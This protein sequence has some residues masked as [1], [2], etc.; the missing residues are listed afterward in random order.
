MKS[1]SDGMSSSEEAKPQQ[2]GRWPMNRWL[3]LIVVVLAAHVALIFTFG[4]RKPVT[5]RVAS[6]V[7]ELE[8]DSRS[9]EWLMLQDPTLFA[10]PSREGFAGAA[11]LE[12]PHLEIHV[13]DW[14]ESPRFLSLLTNKLGATFSQFMQTNR[15]A[16]F[17]FELKP[18]PQFSVPSVPLEP[19]FARTSTLR[20]EG[21]LAQ[22][23][24][25]TA[26]KLPSWPYADIIAPSRVQVLVNAAGEVI[27]TVLLPSDNPTQAR[28][29]DADQRALE[30]A[31]AARFAP[32]SGLTIGRLIFDWHTIAPSATNAASADL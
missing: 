32:S 31:R 9:S 10:L 30:L 14:T 23:Q 29:T 3:L 16:T 22:R 28:D 6:N 8:L 5:P 21:D 17:R 26:M 11:W 12:A 4:G 1:K 24:L 19:T 15:F 13:K 2:K 25:L 18:P 27:S 7:P 20:I